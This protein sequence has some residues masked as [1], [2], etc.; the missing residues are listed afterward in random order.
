MLRKTI[1]LLLTFISITTTALAQGDIDEQNKIFYRN[2]KSYAISLNSN[3]ISIKYR[4]AL[5][6]DAYKSKILDLEFGNLKHPKEIKTSNPYLYNSGRYIYGKLNSLLVLRANYGFQKILY[7][8]RDVGGISIRRIYSLGATLGMLKPIYYQIFLPPYTVVEE[9]F[10]PQKHRVG[11][12]VG[13]ASFMKGLN[14]IKPDPA[15][16]AQYLYSFEF[17]RKDDKIQAFDVGATA[18][19]F[20]YPPKIMSEV[21][22]SPFYLTLFIS[23]RFG[24][25]IDSRKAKIKKLNSPVNLP[26][27]L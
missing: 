23:Y 17:S 6:K 1:V 16:N 4:Y 9:K 8:K 12:I 24:K 18:E 25:V 21:T 19:F 13:T 7:E 22:N 11:D 10:D 5:R 2:E 27:N 3:G 26:D 14:E 15:I 20:L